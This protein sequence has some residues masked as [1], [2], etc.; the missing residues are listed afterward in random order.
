[1]LTSLLST[2]SIRVMLLIM[3]LLASCTALYFAKP[4]LAPAV[5]ALVIGVVVSPVADLFNRYGVPRVLV[6]LA[7]LASATLLLT[8]LLFSID[9][10]IS[11]LTN[12]LPRLK[13]E[14]RGWITGIA[15]TLRGLENIGE[16]IEQTVSGENSDDDSNSAKLPTMMDALW[17]APNFGGQVLIFVGTLFLFVLTRNDL[18]ASAD[19]LCERLF[20]AERA[21]ARY[22]AAVTIVNIGLG[23][24]TAAAL[25]VIGLSNAW[26]WGLGAALLN[27]IPYLGPLIIIFGLAIAGLMQIGGAAAILPPL[28]FLALNVTEGQ[29]VTPL[30]VGRQL[31]LNPLVVFLSIIFGLWLWGPIG[32]IVALPVLLW[33]SRMLSNPLAE[34]EKET[35]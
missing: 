4:F 26:L 5:F 10:V 13:L 18:Y 8:A 19:R 29:F 35:S 11:T 6:A 31:Q 16:E 15:D 28:T 21:V 20:R 22:F 25:A 1:M 12:Q 32:A 14:I 30:F 17:L 2:K 3:T 9:P 27:F 24:A 34:A 23:V 33:C 7:L